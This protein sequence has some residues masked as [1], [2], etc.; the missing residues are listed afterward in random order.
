[1]YD[2]ILF[3]LDGTLTN[4]EEG[5]TKSVQYALKA[6]GIEED[7]QEK[8]KLFIGPPLVDGFMQFYNMSRE[9]ALIAVQ[10]YRERFSDIGIYEN[11]MF[12]KVP[13]MLETLKKNGKKLA[14]ATSK[15]IVYAQRIIKHFGIDKYF[16]IVVGA[17]FDGTRNEKAEVIKEVLN[18]AGV[19]QNAV[20]VGDRKQDV[21]GAIKNDIPCIGVSFGFAPDGELEENGAL[22][23]ADSI[24]EILEILLK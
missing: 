2:L 4:P 13:E 6:F 19:Y 23:I 3:D 1:M 21:I 16:D 9:N 24:S 15:P 12:E 14:L 22:E 17:E 5:I 20:M 7:N 8:L 11:E 18:R 10:K